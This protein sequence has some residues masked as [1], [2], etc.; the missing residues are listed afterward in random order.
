VPVTT[1]TLGYPAE[2]PPLT[3]RLPLEAV[4][5]YEEYENYSKEK[6]EELYQEFEQLPQI[7]KYIEEAK[8]ENLAQVFTNV[9]YTKKDAEYFSEKYMNFLK[10]QEMI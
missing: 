3:E 4:V 5:H 10:E 6:I 9:R 8:Q 2:N 7:K 1:I